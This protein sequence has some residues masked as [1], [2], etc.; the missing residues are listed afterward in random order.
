MKTL[1]LISVLLTS[2]TA[3][4]HEMKKGWVKV[5]FIEGSVP[6]EAVCQ[7]KINV[8]GDIEAVCVDLRTVAADIVGSMKPKMPNSL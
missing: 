7:M 2:C 4:Q 8:D 1:V 3:W 5:D 6:A